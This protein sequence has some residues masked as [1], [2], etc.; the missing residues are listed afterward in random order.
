LEKI[1]AFFDSLRFDNPQ[2]F[3]IGGI[4]ILLLIFLPRI[5]KK[6]G[7]AIDLEYWKPLLT[8]KNTRFLALSIPVVLLTI[9]LAGTLTNPQ[10]ITRSS[11]LIIGKPVMLVI[12]ISG[13]TVAAS[14]LHPEMTGQEAARYT[15][16]N[17][18]SLRSDIS[19]GLIMYSTQNFIARYFTYKNELFVDTLDNEKAI[20]RLNRETNTAAAMATAREFLTENIYGEDKAIVLISDLLL[21]Y[22]DIVETLEEIDKNIAAGIDIYVVSTTGQEGYMYRFPAR[23]GLTV[24]DIYDTEAVAKMYEELTSIKPSPINIKE[25]LSRKNLLPYIIPCVLGVSIVCFVLSETRFRKIP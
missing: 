3:W 15:F 24:L 16:E 25:T 13:S 1:A 11:S 18:I 17:L 14:E 9:L 10:A 23:A 7:L 20:Y 2:Y 5:F 19:F 4:L 8:L 6:Q 22:E 12:D 21:T